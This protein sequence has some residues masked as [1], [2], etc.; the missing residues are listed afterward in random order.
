MI[1]KTQIRTWNWIVGAALSA[2]MGTAC[3]AD[4]TGKVTLTGKVA[5]SDQAEITAVKANTECA[6]M[7]KD[8][9]FMETVVTGNK[10]E[11][12]N[13]IV[14]IK[15]P[16][17]KE[18]KGGK[19]PA[20]VLDQKGCVYLP[21]VVP[22]MVGQPVLTKNSDSTLHN[23]HTLPIDN[24][25][26]NKGMPGGAAPINLGPFPTVENIK[27]KCDVHP[28]MVAY[29]RVLDNPFFATTDETG[30]FKIDATGLPDG[31]YE[32]VF[33]HEKFGDQTK[34]ISVKGGKAE[35]NVVF[36]TTKKAEGP[37]GGINETQVAALMTNP[38]QKCEDGSCCEAPSKAAALLT[39]AKA[40]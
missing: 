20:A 6:K 27:V 21:H 10:D 4:I 8:P 11:L 9:I 23:V 2:T 26:V 28:W 17:G 39:A 14:S 1:Q 12:A 36:D 29:I 34:K 30:T 37:A 40:K 38:G 5:D 18:L 31:D 3:L 25:P 15:T 16:Q 7:H 35:A 33:W 13:V 22:V 19:A 24:N 32:L